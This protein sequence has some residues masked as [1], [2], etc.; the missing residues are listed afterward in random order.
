MFMLVENVG[1]IM[2]DL[3]IVLEALGLHAIRWIVEILLQNQCA[4]IEYIL[5]LIELL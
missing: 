3:Q 1:D 2:L 5:K 4:Y